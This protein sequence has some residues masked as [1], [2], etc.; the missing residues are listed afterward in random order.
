M[1]EH[2]VNGWPHSS[3]ASGTLT[4]VRA[5]ALIVTSALVGACADSARAE[6]PPPNNLIRKY[7]QFGVAFT[8]EFVASP[9]PICSSVVAS[10]ILGP[11]GGIVI[12]A[13]VRSTGPLYFGFAYEFSK[14]DPSQLYRLA[15]LQQ[16]RAEGRFYFLDT[17]RDTQ[18]YLLGT[19]GVFGYGDQWGIDSLGP[20]IGL[21]I[22][23]ETQI[24]TTVV[25]GVSLTYRLLY[26][27]A[28]HD[29]AGSDRRDGLAQLVGID[30]VLEGR[31]PL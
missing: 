13:G 17:R 29:G 1:R 5:L 12:R 4:H 10:C 24:S 25:I 8:G 15:I 11:G 23:S 3:A 27:T 28:F 26:T 30:L 18:P 9:G 7:L 21:G 16:A 31:D 2:H 22:G 14:Q 6:A 19:A 20:T